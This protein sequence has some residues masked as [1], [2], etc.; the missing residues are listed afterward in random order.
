MRKSR[1]LVFSLA[2]SAAVVAPSLAMGQLTWYTDRQAFRDDNRN[3]GKILK[4]IEDFEGS[5][6]PP[7]SVVGMDDPLVFGIPNGPYPDGLSVENLVVQ[8]RQVDGTPRGAGG[9]AAASVG[10]AGAA[11][12]VV[13]ANFFVD[14]LDL[15][16]LD[17]LKSGVGFDTLGFIGGPTVDV[18]VFDLAGNSLGS[19]NF[20]ADPAGSNFAGVW[21]DVAIGRINIFDPADIGGAEGGDNIEMWIVPEPTS[22]IALLGGGLMLLAR[23]LRR[24]A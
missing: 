16:F 11:S 21:S 4:G 12:D 23:R 15:I 19:M 17:E 14:S 7:N 22:M 13:L 20:A 24:K 1:M 10:F 18:E 8:S 5:T 6:L 2:L 3:H 9:L